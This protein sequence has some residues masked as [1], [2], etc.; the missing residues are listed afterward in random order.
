MGS[1]DIEGAQS[2]IV[3][4]RTLEYTPSEPRDIQVYKNENNPTNIEVTWTESE[5]PNGI[6]ENY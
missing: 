5:S 6:I 3:Y 2:D 4:F 1:E